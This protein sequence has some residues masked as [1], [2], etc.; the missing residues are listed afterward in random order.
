MTNL[1]TAVTN[2]Y[3]TLRDGLADDVRVYD[4]PTL[5]GDF[6]NK[7]VFVGY[8]GESEFDL[9]TARAAHEWAG[10]GGNAIH[11]T[12][13]IHCTALAWYPNQPPAYCRERLDAIMDDIES[14]LSGSPN[15]GLG[16]PERS[17]LRNYRF[18]QEPTDQGMQARMTFDISVFSR[19][20]P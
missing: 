11:E 16:S 10:S 17:I 5:T 19:V 8:T 20:R 14:L 2:A 3:T 7:M 4:G 18:F 6:Q 9:E 12:L 13:D 1:N 15:L